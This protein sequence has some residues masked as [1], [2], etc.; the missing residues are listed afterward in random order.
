MIVTT[1]GGEP[2]RRDIDIYPGEGIDFTESV[3][4]VDGEAQNVTGWVVAA[5]IRASYASPILHTFTLTTGADGVRVSATG[6]ETADWAGWPTSVARWD[7]WVTPP[8]SEPTPIVA[9]WVRVHST[10][11]H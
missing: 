8:A 1:I 4:D 11:T 2:T 5:Q 6:D 10:I 9:G 7:L 3:V